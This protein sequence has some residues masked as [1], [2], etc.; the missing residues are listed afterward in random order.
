MSTLKVA[1]KEAI[2]VFFISRLVIF[3]LTYLC[4]STLHENTSLFNFN[5]FATPQY[6]LDAWMHFD[7]FSYMNVAMNGYNGA[8][9]G[10]AA[11]FPLWPL[12]LHS[13]SFQ[14]GKSIIYYYLLGLVLSNL[15]F[16]LA[17]VIFYLLSFEIFDH[18]VAKVALIIVFDYLIY[19]E[20]WSFLTWFHKKFYQV[21]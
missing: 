14:A 12:L 8:S 16:Y 20:I 15:F 4:V 9:P 2:W 19:K 18:Q 7:V 10:A 3:V 17:L 5:C 21:N 13:L 11:F 6:C 1:L